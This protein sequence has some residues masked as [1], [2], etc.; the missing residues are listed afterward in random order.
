[1][2]SSPASLSTD[3]P[4]IAGGT[5]VAVLLPLPLDQPYSY[6]LPDGLSAQPGAI[7]EVPLG[8]RRLPGV[9]W[10]EQDQAAVSRDRLKC[11]L[12]VHDVPP[13]PSVQRRFISWVSGYTL[14]PLG[15]VLRMALSVPAALDPPAP[16]QVLQR[17]DRP[18][19]D[20]L[21]LTPARQRVLELAGQGFAHPPGVLAREAGVSASVVKGLEQA[22]LLQAVSR[23][24]RRS[25]ALPDGA[26][27]GPVLSEGQAG[28]AEALCERVGEAVFSVTLLDGVTGSGKTEVYFE[29]VARALAQGRQV[30][31][32]QPEIALSSQWIERFE[33]RFGVQ[34]AQWHSDLTPAQR[35]TTWRAVAE[36]EARVLVGA[37]SALFL[38]FQDLGLVVVDEEHDPAYKQEDGVIYQARDMAVVRGQLGQ[39][40]VILASAT[41]SLESVLNVQAGKYQL[42]ELPARH[43]GASL[44]EVSV[45]DLRKDRPERLPSGGQS[46]LAPSLRKAITETL[47][48]GEQALLF[49]N[50][51][52]YAPLTLCRT[53]GHRIECPDCTAWLVEHRKWG[54]L[55]CHHCGYRAALPRTCPSC[56]ETDSLVAC[57]PGVERLDEEVRLLFPD[58][59]HLLLS[60]DTLPGPAAAQDLM[61][62]IQQR[63]VN[64]IVGTQI[65]AKGHHFPWLTLVGVVDADL[66]LGGGD[67]RAGER[68]YQLLQQVSGRAGR[69]ERPG[70]V[71]LQSYIPEH[72]VLQALQSGDR[73][74]FLAHEADTRERGFLPPFSRMAALVISAPSAEQADAA[75]RAMAKAAP[76]AE[77]LEV[78]GPAPAPLAVLRGRHR[79]RFLVKARRDLALQ[80][81][82][83]DW[84]NRVRLPGAVRLAIDVDPYSFL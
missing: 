34:P 14:A 81:C 15:N 55:Q 84:R 80:R 73:D 7:V 69:A 11:V 64:L 33:R 20:D 12:R 29:A 65:V 26:R 17:S 49:L 4:V 59:R 62:Q 27:P 53:C 36:G 44:P 19:P 6:L 21:R 13:M 16:Q 32:L 57:G 30:L 50:R 76:Q 25:F 66:G 10:Q 83:A 68:T 5:V 70:R 72:P 23:R 78:L 46:W 45:L 61:R 63:D 51:R 22:G 9:I 47:E 75:S 40:P 2:L 82:L 54:Q 79:R 37:R 43:G 31:V 1:M 48:Q 41:P 67:L 60:S 58:A 52:G 71:L 35:R 42:A 77:G 24:P 18:L 56:D 38:P 39:F 74:A 8:Q 28:V 3:A